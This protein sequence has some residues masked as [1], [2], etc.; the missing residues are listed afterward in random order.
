MVA[1]RE[2]E[3][4]RTELAMETRAQEAERAMLAERRCRFATELARFEGQPARIAFRKEEAA[5]LE[6]E[7]A[8]VAQLEDDARLKADNERDPVLQQMEETAVSVALSPYVLDPNT[9]K[10]RLIQ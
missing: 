7:Q 3:Q 4:Q 5:L 1:W 9:N 6:E 2:I 10:I 8:L